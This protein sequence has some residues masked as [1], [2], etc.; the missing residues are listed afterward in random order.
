MLGD[1]EL[2]ARRTCR[3]GQD[4]VAGI[5]ERVCDAG[6]SIGLASSTSTGG[7]SAVRMSGSTSATSGSVNENVVPLP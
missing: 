7:P 3:C 5:G 1:G 4:P 2:D 6:P